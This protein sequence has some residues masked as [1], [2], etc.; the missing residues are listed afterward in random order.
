MKFEIY[1]QIFD[2][3]SN[4]KLCE[5]QSSGSLIVSCGRTFMTTL[6][7]HFCNFAEPSI[8]GKDAILSPMKPFGGSRSL[9]TAIG[10]VEWSTSCPGLFTPGKEPRYPLS[11]IMGGPQSRSGRSVGIQA[12]DRSV[13]SLADVL[14]PLSRSENVNKTTKNSS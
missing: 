5:T 14:A 2:K 9:T 12:P 8:K 10:G 4:I 6:I 7:V 11:R 13:R 3:Y 1:R